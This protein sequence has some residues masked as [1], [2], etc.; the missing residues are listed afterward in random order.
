MI[1]PSSISLAI[2]RCTYDGAMSGYMVNSSASVNPLTDTRMLCST[3]LIDRIECGAVL[4]RWRD[5]GA[6]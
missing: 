4:E 1:R 3:P 5:Y 2:M 6:V